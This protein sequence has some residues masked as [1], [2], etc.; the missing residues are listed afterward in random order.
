MRPILYTVLGLELVDLAL[1]IGGKIP[2]DF[3][4]Q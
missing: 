3:L 4:A 2:W 1:T